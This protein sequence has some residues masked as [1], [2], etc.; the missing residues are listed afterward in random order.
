MVISISKDKKLRDIE[1]NEVSFVDR[2]ANKTQFLI[3]KS[4]GHKRT[5]QMNDALVT[6]LKE[7]LGV[8]TLDFDEEITKADSGVN[9]KAISDAVTELQKYS[10]DLPEKLA[11]AQS[12]LVKHA[13]MSLLGKDTSDKGKEGEDMDKAGK[14]HSNAT[15]AEL[16]DIRAK[17]TA[18]LDPD[19]IEKADEELKLTDTEKRIIK[20]HDELKAQLAAV[21]AEKA[22]TKKSEDDDKDGDEK[23]KGEDG[24]EK[25][26]DDKLAKFEKRLANLEDGGANKTSLSKEEIAAAKK[27]KDDDKTGDEEDWKFITDAIDM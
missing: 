15:T 18:L 23:D 10:N 13:V 21:I 7:Y 26:T 6:L 8:E 11:G 24:K 2:P 27:E 12:V 1:V 9:V 19:D 3:V 22:E 4:D 5:I 17:V 16:L 25:K 14:K 20:E